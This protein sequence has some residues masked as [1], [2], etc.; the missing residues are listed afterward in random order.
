MSTLRA[1]TL[2]SLAATTLLAC[3]PADDKDQPSEPIA[4]DEAAATFARQICAGLFACSC[5]ATISYT[6]EAECVDQLTADY[7]EAIDVLLASG[8][9]WNDACAGQLV[10][11]W[12]DWQCLGPE[13]ASFTSSFDPRVCPVLEGTLTAGAQCTLMA[14]GDNCGPGLS[15]LSGI[16]IE[17]V[18]PVPVGEVCEIDWDQLPCVTGSYCD[19][20][21]DSGI[22]ICQALPSAGD[23][24]DPQSDYL[25]GPSSR[26]LFCGFETGICEPAPGVGEPCFDGFL[27]GPGNYCDGGKDFTCQARFELGDGCGADAVCP[28][29]SSCISNICQ[30]DQAAACNLAQFQLFNP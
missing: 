16:C 10:D 6:D 8:T 30:S 22:R 21:D 29:D 15:C 5:D 3:K 11:A 7:Q 4:V 12:V 1:L 23:P 2:L 14:L 19:Y 13:A 28:I 20:D 17:A 27:C 9:T 26:D 24:C 18:V 25:C